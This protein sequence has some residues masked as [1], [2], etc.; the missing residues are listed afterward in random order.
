MLVLTRKVGEIVR[1]GDDVQIT[2]VEIRGGA[3]RIGIAAPRDTM[4]LRQEV[5]E[6]IERERTEPG[7]GDNA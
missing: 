6:A 5:Y 2:V 3:V 4:V 1:V 7:G